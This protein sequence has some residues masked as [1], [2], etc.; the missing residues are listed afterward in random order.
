MNILR[1]LVRKLDV[2]KDRT[3]T[4]RIFYNRDLA[5]IGDAILNYVNTLVVSAGYVPKS[6]K[7]TNKMLREV[8]NKSGL[9][10][11]I[12]KRQT[13]R[14]LGNVVEAIIAY[15]IL[16]EIL[17]EEQ[18]IEFVTEKGSFEEALVYIL[19][20]FYRDKGLGKLS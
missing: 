5:K 18:I 15:L 3:P 10:K 1:E 13:A 8:V 12:R 9:R 4:E 16:N 6:S 11:D 19:K 14:A 17:T 2:S 20:N 7:V